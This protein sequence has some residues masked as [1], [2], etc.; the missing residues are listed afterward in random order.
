[1]K[2]ILSS[3]FVALTLLL[4][5]G[6]FTTSCSSEILS[7]Q[8]V[9]NTPRAF[10][11]KLSAGL[12]AVQAE[13][14][15]EVDNPRETRAAAIDETFS[16]N[17]KIIDG[18]LRIT[19]DDGRQT[20]VP[21]KTGQL[22]RELFIKLNPKVKLLTVVRA[23]NRP[24]QVYYDYSEWRYDKLSDLYIKDYL[25]IPLSAGFTL[26]DEIE[27]RLALGGHTQVS[28]DGSTCTIR[29]HDNLYKQ[30]D[31][32][33]AAAAQ[34]IEMP[35]PY[36]SGWEA[37]EYDASTSQMMLANANKKVVLNPQG[38][39]FLV[40]MRNNMEE[41]LTIKGLRIVTNAFDY[42]GSFDLS[43]DNVEFTPTYTSAERVDMR[44]MNDK[45]RSKQFLFGD[46]L[47]LKKNTT[48]N[49]F[50]FN[51]AKVLVIWVMPD[52]T[53]GGVAWNNSG[54]ALQTAQTH[55]YGLDV[56]DLSGQEITKPNY[57]IVPIMGTVN[58]LTPGKSFTLN[59]EF[60]TQPPQL[61]GF[62]AKYPVNENG[63][64]FVNTHDDDKTPLV[65]WKVAKDFISGK[66]IT[67]PD[68]TKQRFKMM[69]WGYSNLLGLGAYQ[70]GFRGTGYG[71]LGTGAVGKAGK[72]MVFDGTSPSFGLPKIQSDLKSV[73][74]FYSLRSMTYVPENPQPDGKSIA[75]RLIGNHSGKNKSVLIRNS[76]LS[77]IRFEVE[78]GETNVVVH[79]H[80]TSI[81]LGKYWVGNLLTPVYDDVTIVSPRFWANPDNLRNKVERRLPA[82]GTYDHKTLTADDSDSPIP[83]NPKR[84]HVGERAIFWSS[85]TGYSPRASSFIMEKYNKANTALTGEQW[86]DKLHN[87]FRFSSTSR[88]FVIGSFDYN[89][90][91]I[92][93]GW[94]LVDPRSADY[95]N[96]DIT[97]KFLFLPLLVYSERSYQGDSAD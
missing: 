23:R 22:N 91:K 1:M 64:G 85:G 9:D 16:F 59:C 52:G 79:Q 54:P 35:I 75:F 21:Q 58:T 92:E 45:F 90:R 97:R 70:I 33:D 84:E 4:V 7:T 55:V 46:R 71:A 2:R 11:L 3:L 82:S 32:S 80:L 72:L 37:L 68:G 15:G 13:E 6:A 81:Y 61:L 14:L 66:D 60:Y 42:E 83:A 87:E 29:M 77:V 17:Y 31:L 36:V 24:T 28:E 49:P 20:N 65:N 73:N 5:G 25:S 93:F 19:N 41:D 69:D 53:P 44:L 27:V 39:L 88:P 40:T 76:S 56:R 95:K 10:T 38:V 34:N 62:L 8:Q 12:G 47:T 86:I 30:I 63:D 26:S 18:K 67:L 57:H 50:D 43:K 51:H 48:R 78:E 96:R 74:S 94:N 89:F